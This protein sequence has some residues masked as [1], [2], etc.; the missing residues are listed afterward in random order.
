MF[1]QLNLGDN[2]FALLDPDDHEDL[3]HFR[4]RWRPI[5]NCNE[6][7][8]ARYITVNGKRRLSYLQNEIMQPP[9]GHE[10]IFRN[11]NRLDCRRFNLRVVTRKVARRH[12]AK[13]PYTCG[14]K[15]IKYSRREKVWVAELLRNGVRQHVGKFRCQVEA[16][17]AYERTQKE[18]EAH[19][20]NPT[21]RLQKLWPTDKDL[22]R[23]PRMTCRDFPVS[24]RRNSSVDVTDS[25]P[26]T[27]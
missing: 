3:A 22:R 20:Q 26:S 18:A 14:L 12:R 25:L 16:V 24:G 15:G 21:T 19:Q 8:A 23:F 10:V 11:R 9:E 7:Q 13:C 4:W 6:V 5:S 27:P 2:R 1:D 17:L